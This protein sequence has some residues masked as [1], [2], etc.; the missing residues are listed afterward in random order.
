MPDK[1]TPI[2]NG[3]PLEALDIRLAKAVKAARDKLHAAGFPYVIADS[4]GKGCLDVYPDGHTEFTPYLSQG[5]TF[6]GR[7]SAE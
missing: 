3:E 1:K 6:G 5:R 2:N 4:S 7:D